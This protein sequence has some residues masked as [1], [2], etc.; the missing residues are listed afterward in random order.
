MVANVKRKVKDYM[1]VG[2]VIIASIIIFI[3]R[4]DVARIGDLGYI[5]VFLLCLLSNLTVFLPS[6]SLLVVTSYASVLSPILVCIVGSLGST[7][8]EMSGYLFGNSMGELSKKWNSFL[9]RVNH[10]I[11]NIYILIFAFALIPLPLFDFVGV[12]AGGRKVKIPYFF[13][14]CY[15]G[16]L[17]KMFFYSYVVRNIIL[18]IANTYDLRW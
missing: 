16:K 6:P 4:K 9:E 13:V 3:F 2:L 5:G 14:A 10:K 17:L 12:Y 15:I 8:G 7:I 18:Q 1:I 11:K